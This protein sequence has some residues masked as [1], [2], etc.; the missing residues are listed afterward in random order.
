[1]AENF[2]VD[3]GGV[4]VR[5]PVGFQAFACA[6]YERCSLS[7]LQGVNLQDGDLVQIMSTCAQAAGFESCS[8]PDYCVV[9][10]SQR[11]SKATQSGYLGERFQYNN[12]TI[13]FG[14]E[15]IRAPN[16][17]YRLCWCGAGS[18]AS[19]SSPLGFAVDAG[20]ITIA[21]PRSGQDRT[22]FHSQ[23]C[24]IYNI[25]GSFLEDGDRLMLLESCRTGTGL[26]ETD[27]PLIDFATRGVLG[28]PDFGRSLP[29]TDNGATFT[30]GPDAVTTGGK[31][32]MCWCSRQAHDTLP[33]DRAERFKIE[34]GMLTVVGFAEN[35]RR[36]FI[37]QPCEVEHL[38]SWHHASPVARCSKVHLCSFF[39]C[40]RS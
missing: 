39:S 27:T 21:G 6:T 22:C 26:T 31:Y 40:S 25:T 35:K 5:A 16:G 23:S 20:V 11:S 37:G 15:E 3:I 8:A 38:V 36:C 1:M 14:P 17:A 10:G 12:L 4:V 13:S 29:A 7:E 34:V 33:C 24:T 28:F 18:G 9:P 30:W 2:V 32:K 19:C